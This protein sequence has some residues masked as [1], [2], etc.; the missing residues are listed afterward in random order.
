MSSSYNTSEL[1]AVVGIGCRFPGASSLAELADV[2]SNPADLSQTIPSDRFSIDGYHHDDGSHHGSTNVRKS[3][4]LQGNIRKFDNNFFNIT[5]VEASSI[6]PQQRILLETVHEAFENANVSM[7]RLRGSDTAVY[8]GL[9]CGDYEN[10]LNS[11]LDTAPR[12]QATGVSRSIIANRISYIWDLRGP[13]MTIDTACSSSLVA[14]HQGVQALRLGETNLAVVAGS[15]L[16]LG[17]EWYITESNLNMLSPTGKSRMW[18]AEANGYARGEGV[19]AVVLKRLSDAVA[20]GDFIECIVRETGVGQ[21]GRTNGITTPGAESQASLIRRVYAK[22]GLDVIKDGCQYFEAHGTGTPAGDPVEAEAIHSVFIDSSGNNARPDPLYVGSVKTVIGHTEGTAGLAGLIKTTAALQRKTIFPN[23]HFNKLNPRIAPFYGNLKVPTANVP[24]PKPPNGQ[25]LRA[26]VNSFGFGGTNS[27]VILE[28]YD[29]NVLSSPLTEDTVPL[30]V[31]TILSAKSADSLYGGLA[32]YGQWL[33]LHPKVNIR[34]VAIAAS[35][36]SPFAYRA[37]IPAASVP[38]LSTKL[39]EAIRERRAVAP[40]RSDPRTIGIFTGQGAQSFGM[41]AEVLRASPWAQNRARQL[42][43]ALAD[44]IPPEDKPPQSLVDQLLL[45][46]SPDGSSVMQASLS[47]PLCTMIQILLVDV[48]RIA[49]IDFGAVVGHSSG[50]MA[51][52]YA[53]GYLTAESALGAAYYRGRHTRLAGGDS[54][55]QGAMLAASMSYKEARRFCARP[56][57]KGRICVA[58]SN[59]PGSVTLSGDEDAILEAEEYLEVENANPKRLVVD[60]AYHSHHMNPCSS[61]YLESLRALRGFESDPHTSTRWFSSVYVEEASKLKLTSDYWNNN[62]VQP[63]LFSQALEKACSD[64]GSFDL[65]IEVGPHP[66]LRGPVLQT[67]KSLEPQ[68]QPAYAFLLRRREDSV[69]SF[70]EGFAQLWQAGLN[71]KLAAVDKVMS[72]FSGQTL[73]G[74]PIYHW[75]HDQEFWHES[76]Y[77]KAFRRRKQPVHPLIGK[78]LPD[79]SDLDLRWRNVLLESELPWLAGHKIQGQTIFP[80]T[81]YLCMAIEAAR[82]LTQSDQSI[83]SLEVSN[84]DIGQALLIPPDDPGIEV[85]CTMTN[86]RRGGKT[87][88]RADFSMYSALSDSLSLMAKATVELR[89]GPSKGDILPFTRRQDIVDCLMG[90]V[91]TDVIYAAW[92]NLGYGYTGPFRAIQNASRKLSAA[93]GSIAN[94]PGGGSMLLHPA[95]LDAAIQTILLAYCH[96]D[97]GDL[98]STHVPRTIRSVRINFGLAK[99]VGQ[100]HPDFVFRAIIPD[101]EGSGLSGDV[102]LFTREGHGVVQLE[103]IQC[104]QLSPATEESDSRIF[105]QTKWMAALPDAQSVCVD[106]RPTADDYELAESLERL[107]FYYMTQLEKAFPQGHEKRLHPNWR[108]YFGFLAHVRSLVDSGVHP[109]IKKDW[110]QDTSETIAAIAARYPHNPDRKVVEAVGENVAQ[111]IHSGGTMLEHPLRGLLDDYYV[112]VMTNQS[113]NRYLARVVGQLVHKLPLMNILEIGVGNGSVT[114]AVL[115]EIGCTFD[116]YTCTDVSV[117][118]FEKARDVFA[119]QK[120]KMVFSSLDPERDVIEQGFKPHLYDLVIT[121]LTSRATSDLEKTISNIRNLLR[122]GGHLVMLEITDSNPIKLG[123]VFGTMPQWWIGD[124]E[125]RVLSPFIEPPKWSAILQQSGFSGIDSITPDV[126]RLLFPFSV[127]TAQAVDDR[128]R[129]LRNPL[130][131]KTSL[132]RLLVVGG[133]TPITAQLVNSLCELSGQHYEVVI[134]IRTFEDFNEAYSGSTVLSLS[135]LDGPVFENI[136]D[137]ALDALKTIVSTCPVL[138]WVTHGARD[139]CPGSMMSIGFFRSVVWE[140]PDL[141]FRSIDFMNESQPASHVIYSSLLE[142]EVAVSLGLKTKGTTKGTDLL[143]PL[144]REL[145]YRNGHLEIP[146]VIPSPDLNDRY[147]ASRRLILRK[148]GKGSVRLSHDGWIEQDTSALSRKAIASK[149][150]K[151]LQLKVEYSTSFSVPILDSGLS[152]SFLVFGRAEDSM[153]PILALV[154][155]CASMV[156]PLPCSV[157]EVQEDCNPP[158]VLTQVASMLQAVYL[159]SQVHQGQRLLVHNPSTELALAIKSLAKD[160][161]IRVTMTS[162]DQQTKFI[163]LHP[164]MP[165]RLLRNRIGPSHHYFADLSE[166]TESPTE[167]P[168]RQL[169]P[170]STIIIDTQPILANDGLRSAASTPY[171]GSIESSKAVPVSAQLSQA[172]NLGHGLPM[173][174]LGLISLGDFSSQLPNLNKNILHWNATEDALIRVLPTDRHLAFLPHRTYWLVGLTG[175]FGLSLSEWLVRKGAR[176]VVLSSR[177]PKISPEWLENQRKAG[178]AIAVIPCDTADKASLNSAYEQIKDSLPPLAGVAQGAMVM[179][180]ASILDMDAQKFA[181]VAGPKVSGSMNLDELLEE[182]GD[183]LDFFVFFSS[184]VAIV[185]NHGQS[186]YSAAN[187]FMQTLTLQRRHRGRAASV[188]NLG[189][190]IGI[191][192]AQNQLHRSQRESLRKNGF[193]WL[194]EHHLH[195]AF[196]EAVLASP[197]SSKLDHEITLG[198]D[199]FQVD[200]PSV[201]P[202]AEE[203]RQSHRFTVDPN[204]TRASMG[205]NVGV[206]KTPRERL[207]D[208]PSLKDAELVIKE[209]FLLELESILKLSLSQME[210]EK[211]LLDSGNDQLGFDSLIA[212]EVRRWFL[213]TFD[214][215]IATLQ[216]LNTTVRGIIDLALS[217]LDKPSTLNLVMETRGKP[218]DNAT[219]SPLSESDSPQDIGTFTPLSEPETESTRSFT[220]LS[221]SSVDQKIHSIPVTDLTNPQHSPR[222]GPHPLSIGQEMFWFVHKLLPDANTL[223]G[224]LVYHLTGSPDVARLSEAVRVV[225]ERHEAMRTAV[226]ELDDGTAVQAILDEAT[227]YLETLSASEDD[228]SDIIQNFAN[229][230]YQLDQGQ[231]M[232]ILLVSTS[233]MKHY[234]FFGSHHIHMDGISLQVIQ[235]ELESFYKGEEFL[236]SPLQFTD[237]ARRQRETDW[238]DLLTFWQSELSGISGELP[239]L[240][241]P[242][243]AK[244][245]QPLNEYRS[246][247]IGRRLDSSTMVKVRMRCRELRVTQFQFYLAIFRVLLVRLAKVDDVCIGIADANRLSED[248]IE[249][250]GMYL[251]LLPLR[252]RSTCNKTFS[253]IAQDTKA[254]VQSAIAHSALP[255]GLLLSNM[256]Q[257]GLQRSAEHTPIF[258]AFVDYRQGAR[259]QMPFGDCNLD[260]RIWQGTKA[261]YDISLDIVDYKEVPTYIRLAVQESLYSKADAELLMDSYINL[262]N[263]FA[264]STVQEQN[265]IESVPIFDGKSIGTGLSISK[266]QLERSSWPVTVAHRFAE[267][268]D[269]YP[270][271]PAIKDGNGTVLTYASMSYWVAAIASG[272]RKLQVRPGSVVGVFQEPTAGFVCSML[273]IWRTGCVYMP[274]DSA[275]PLPRLESQVCH[276][277]PQLILADNRLA[278]AAAIF[279]T[280][281]LNVSSC[282][283]NLEPFETVFEVAETHPTDAAA[284]FY[285]S[286]STGVPKGIVISHR[287]L[288]HELEFSSKSYDFGF[289][290]VLCQSA[291]GFDMSLTQIFTA[292]AYGGCVH[293]VSLA[294]RGDA[295]SITKRIVDDGITFTGA[296]PSEYLSWLTYGFPALGQSGS[297]W[298]RAVCGGEPITPALL[299]AFASVANPQLRLFNAYGPTETTCSVTRIEVPFRD[300]AQTSSKTRLTAGHVAPNCSICI[301]DSDLRPLPVGMSGEVLIGGAKVAVGYFGNDA[302]TQERFLDHDHVP[303]QF[304]AEGW[305][306]VHRTGDVGRLLP[307][308]Q[309]L[310]E[311]RVAGDSQIKL[312]GNRVDLTDVEDAILRAGKG[313]LIEAL[314]V[315]TKGGDSDNASSDSVLLSALVVTDTSIHQHSAEEEKFLSDLLRRVDLPRALRPTIIRPVQAL[316]KSA[317]GKVDRKAAAKLLSMHLDTTEET[318]EDDA[319]SA[320]ESQLQH[321]W[322]D[323]LPFKATTPQ[324]HKSS[325]FFHAGGNSLLLVALQKRIREVFGVQ[326]SLVSLFDQST[327]FNMASLIE[328]SSIEEKMIDWDSETDPNNCIPKEYIRSFEAHNLSARGSTVVVLTGATGLL[329]KALLRSLVPDERISAIHCISVRK[330]DHLEPFR[331]SG[332]VVVHEGDLTLPRLGLSTD[333]AH[334][335]F[336]T[337]DVIIHNGADVSHLKSY[338]TIKSANLGSTQELVKLTLESGRPIHFHF[339]STAGVSLYSGLDAFGEVSSAPF[340]PP[341]DNSDGYTASKWA[342]ERFLERVHGLTDLPVWVHRPSNIHRFEDPQFDLFQ[343]LLRYSR[344]LQAVPRFSSMQGHLNLVEAVDVAH[345]ICSDIFTDANSEV[346]YRHCISKNNMSMDKLADFIRDRTDSPVEVL[347]VHAWSARAEAQGLSETVSEWFKKVALG[348]PVK[349]PL[350]VTEE[351]SGASRC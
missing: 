308:G 188:I 122:P 194:S 268:S 94:T 99:D 22:A 170:K 140:M 116:T 168:I 84:L 272:I 206:Q 326:L 283:D 77:T 45:G 146:R 72:G 317:N 18:D 106:G 250:V 348:A 234:L 265:G 85:I 256:G 240:P 149:R 238:S 246:T 103:G 91:D 107:A 255:F 5:A 345:S 89:L 31:P 264:S 219:S 180:D 12:Y 351:V 137:V 232:R 64:V 75:Q 38:E 313:Q 228:I 267:I 81:G 177:N 292:L 277:S 221:S 159:L 205:S 100:S 70:R 52:A 28:R 275:T 281:V 254:K 282:I 156:K 144:E 62:M 141:N 171:G 284:V 8:V 306:S 68:T 113:Y 58:A 214:V 192:Y 244:G 296:T 26:S 223:N 224:T 83:Q 189:L 13:S 329:G 245:R 133:G 33:K 40:T 321:A 350:L 295:L 346:N 65:V 98:F 165:A 155:Q 118:R 97:D 166:A 37:A 6:D 258:Q 289:E 53:A 74:L 331:D 164:F 336:S 183:D 269:S 48:L 112:H 249:A 54:G 339:V 243:A 111:V 340:P 204:M 30:F 305:A 80:A 241:L 114:K 125:G 90:P 105:L 196:G 148:S 76:R 218:R 17:P 55:Q 190:V 200:S 60:K 160:R 57:F 344:L 138:M 51:A 82:E 347:E 4:F 153:R 328:R 150:G 25:P 271:K 191:G 233:P 179:E 237:F 213:K 334:S 288:V 287:N 101:R 227:V 298:H 126:D 276:C 229:H 259:E 323:V 161:G 301:V 86:V 59:S 27:H 262:V 173:Q 169:L 274:L 320:V 1:I 9:M 132:P 261:A 314:C 152:K 163:H 217:T 42:E 279:G 96:P 290:N 187:A 343:N 270:E 66:A 226:F 210:D 209:C 236:G 175:D 335:I 225:G 162:T 212:M 102:E 242:D 253:E 124:A 198:L 35:R 311:G 110:L 135:D 248:S 79:S 263:A 178:A 201:P 337:A 349:Y 115:E 154:P 310:L 29:N 197:S 208:A 157:C 11:D 252:F 158:L 302:L 181:K 50:E 32:D 7:P 176:Y 2:L 193:I 300:L 120:D 195:C 119:A 142:L 184:S 174:P 131:S 247:E 88:I 231:T 303:D 63:V 147:N 202:W 24:W 220:P 23:K 199:A 20:D 325:D 87:E 41:M 186:N 3:Y 319:L 21:D 136:N 151:R 239:I 235:S 286:G 130:A 109:H 207:A 203:P 117:S 47:Q 309:L 315:L 327:L 123:F 318:H 322:A 312:R 129:L 39:S 293:I 324:I 222:Y 172:Y 266:G 167:A 69:Q 291:L 43:Q 338:R 297:R 46:R 304:I 316:P 15:N 260:V 104:V 216:I 294:E 128:V 342:S 257:L 332:K 299:N 280:R 92:N 139:K 14:L 330:A 71:P 251:N 49:G 16:L 143:W 182:R 121:S 285:T 273:A 61:A 341:T 230:R 56:E 185:G 19:A 134:N 108:R 211:T 34:D 36:R 95:T 67:L 93:S 307:D 215:K 278:D 145:V 127:I 333:E 78:L 10:I 44:I 73:R